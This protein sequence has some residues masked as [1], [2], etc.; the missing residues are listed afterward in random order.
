MD[1]YVLVPHHGA[2]RGRLAR[3]GRAAVYCVA[4]PAATAALIGWCQ[5]VGDRP[6]GDTLDELADLVARSAV[7]AVAAFVID[8]HAI[9]AFT[10][11]GAP[12]MVDGTRR[13]ADG[14]APQREHLDNATSVELAMSQGP[15]DPYLALESGVVAA[16]G[17][18]LRHSPVGPMPWG[19]LRDEAGAEPMAAAEAMAAAEPMVPLAAAEPTTPPAPA[20]QAPEPV[21]APEPA[22]PPE[23]EPEL[24]TEAMPPVVMA[25][26]APPNIV[27]LLQGED[28]LP[29]AMP[30]PV[31]GGPAP[32]IAAPMPPD[33][34]PVGD[35]TGTEVRVQGLRCARDHF[36]DPRARFCAVCGIAMHQASFVLTEDVR[37]PLGVITFA[38]GTF[39]RITGNLVF[40]R[41]PEEDPAVK[42]GQAMAAVL[43]DPANTISRTHAEVRALDWDVYLVDRGSTNG[44]FVWNPPAQ[45]W[46]RLAPDEPRVIEPGAQISFGRLVAA[47]DSGL[48]P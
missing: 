44:T 42:S 14:P 20:E 29:E 41:D 45:Q 16:D 31:A 43:V 32:S 40:G 38:D 24:L 7:S 46:D 26:E 1:H 19:S 36:N 9:E 17:F 48:R 10:V 28:D 15:A 35:A 6:A 8:G 11:G 30:L 2:G 23:P 25:D 3:S 4:D 27:S 34:A 37:P 21:M 18:S 5:L 33:D 13:L 47:F 22:A 39:Y 12:V